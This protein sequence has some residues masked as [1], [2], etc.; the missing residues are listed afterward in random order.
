M[1]CGSDCKAVALQLRIQAPEG[2]MV[3]KPHQPTWRDRVRLAVLVV[4]ESDS[5]SH[6][7]Y[8]DVQFEPSK[9]DGV[10]ALRSENLLP[11][12]RQGLVPGDQKHV[13]V[14]WGLLG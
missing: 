12:S 10:R 5:M 1:A 4:P 13:A 6:T 14:R 9:P 8:P 11:G 2:S 7:Y 3:N